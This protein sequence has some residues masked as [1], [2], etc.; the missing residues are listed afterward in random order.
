MSEKTELEKAAER[1]GVKEVR[2]LQGTKLVP[3]PK[4]G[5]LVHP[6][7]VKQYWVRQGLK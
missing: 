1:A 4:T 7:V 3:H 2:D 5:K 6:N